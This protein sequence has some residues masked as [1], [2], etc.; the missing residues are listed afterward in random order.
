MI[1]RRYAHRLAAP[2]RGSLAGDRAGIAGGYRGGLL[3]D[4]Q[5]AR[6]EGMDRAVEGVH[7]GLG[8]GVDHLGLAGADVTGA[9][10][11]LVLGRGPGGERVGD[12]VL[13]GDLDALTGLDVRVG[14][15]ELE[16]L[17]SD[18]DDR[19]A[20]AGRRGAA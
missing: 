10:H 11:V 1:R 15:G 8:R 4:D 16:V 2:G 7:A 5:D 12:R 17:D 18:L 3:A 14:R 6:H 9:E 20:A 19:T 13:V